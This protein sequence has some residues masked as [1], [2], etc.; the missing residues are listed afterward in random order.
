MRRR[1]DALSMRRHGEPRPACCSASR[2]RF[3]A[4]A[5]RG[6][7]PARDTD[8]AVI[9]W[10]G[11]G[12]TSSGLAELMSISLL[13]PSA[14]SRNVRV[15]PAGSAARPRGVERR[16]RS[17]RQASQSRTCRRCAASSGTHVAFAR[18]AAGHR[19]PRR[20]RRH[21]V[22]VVAGRLAGRP[23]ALRPR[24]RAQRSVAAAGSSRAIAR[25]SRRQRVGADAA[26]SIP[27]DPHVGD[28]AHLV[29]AGPACSPA[30][31]TTIVCG[32]PTGMPMSGIDRPP[33]PVRS[34]DLAAPAVAAT[35]PAWLR[36]DV[37]ARE[38][39]VGP[40]GQQQHR[41]AVG[42]PE[43]ERQRVRRGIAAE[44]ASSSKSSGY[45]PIE[46]RRCVP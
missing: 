14:N 13:N 1:R 21:A 18:V 25:S 41:A 42:R 10:N 43:I 27:V 5:C 8:S 19:L 28:D 22:V 24:S 17:R 39:V 16:A 30:R 35:R 2:Y 11:S 40:A 26:I 44:R 3:D 37:V 29:L 12:A 34:L 4:P 33:A 6:S 38:R 31:S 45:W 32:R 36:R 15:Q 23:A 9:P 20:H 46:L 7:A